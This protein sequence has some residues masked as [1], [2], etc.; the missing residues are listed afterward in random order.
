[1]GYK[2]QYLVPNTLIQLFTFQKLSDRE[3][4]LGQMDDMD[5]EKIKEYDMELE[6]ALREL[7]VERPGAFHNQM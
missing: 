5:L 6:R 7:A 3:T 4:A 2:I 1:M